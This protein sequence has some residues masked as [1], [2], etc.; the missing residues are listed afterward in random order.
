MIIIQLSD[1]RILAIEV[2]EDAFD[3]KLHSSFKTNTID[4]FN[5]IITFLVKGDILGFEHLDGYSIRDFKILG[6]ANE[7]TE[8]QAK[9]I[10][11]KVTMRFMPKDKG[12]EGY[13][14][15]QHIQ[16]G[17]SNPLQSFQSLMQAKN[18]KPTDLILIE[19]KK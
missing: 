13:R 12:Y 14:D 1:K 16:A 6:R 11:E 5:N 10:V 4:C 9:E 15:Y 19:T 2:P 18:I 7:I 8:E 3:F 17:Y